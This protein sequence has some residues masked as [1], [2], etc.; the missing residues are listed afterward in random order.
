MVAGSANIITWESLVELNLTNV[1]IEYSV[2]NGQ[3]WQYVDTVQNSIR[4]EVQRRSW[5]ETCNLIWEI[6]G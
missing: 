3:S 2:D 4:K 5:A 6:P 1:K